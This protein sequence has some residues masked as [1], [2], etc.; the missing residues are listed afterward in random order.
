M[1]REGHV[2]DKVN[3]IPRPGT[4]RLLSSKADG[5][6]CFNSEIGPVVKD[7][8][9]EN[10]GDDAVA[11]HG[12]FGIAFKNSQASKTIEVTNPFVYDYRKGMKLELYDFRN[13]NYY[14]TAH[15]VYVEIISGQDAVSRIDDLRLTLQNEG[16]K[17]RDFP[18][19][20]IYR[21]TLDKP[22]ILPNDAMVTNS[23]II[24]AGFQ[25]INNHIK[26]IISRGILI[27][28]NNGIVKGNDIQY[29]GQS[30]I[31]LLS[32]AKYW[33]EGPFNK[34]IQIESNHL[35]HTCISIN[36]RLQ[37]KALG[38]I[39][40][41]VEK[42]TDFSGKFLNENIIIRDNSV[43]NSGTS[44]ISVNSM[45][46]SVIE[47]NTITK[48]VGQEP[49]TNTSN[50]GIYIGCS[51]GLN[52]KGNVFEDLS[53]WQIDTIGYAPCDETGSNETMKDQKFL[54]YPN[55]SRGSFKVVL[56]RKYFSISIYD[57]NGNKYFDKRHVYDTFEIKGKRFNTGIFL[58][59]LTSEDQQVFNQKLLVL[60]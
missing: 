26:N 52:L 7:C 1:E 37:K 11:I 49:L 18:N 14:D 21:I 31:A 20:N 10:L 9:I 8:R 43:F 50:Y 4:G 60:N 35:D 19:K 51:N 40:V 2:F 25:V 56:P 55:P 59:R 29:I 32:E 57:L 30:G 46:N 45:K 33:L 39:A 27:K 16:D 12:F 38:A 41:E 15:I 47:G 3:I 44:G 5:I 34:N 54:I 28:S 42:D 24:C 48:A 36:S 6:H 13:L 17:V 22:V 58:V 23:D 53:H